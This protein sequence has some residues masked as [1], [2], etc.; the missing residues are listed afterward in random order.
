MKNVPCGTSSVTCSKAATIKIGSGSN[1][2]VINLVKGQNYGMK[3]YKRIQTRD[4]GVLISFEVFDLGLVIHWDKGNR[5]YI[6]LTPKWKGNVAGLCGNFNGD[7][8]DDFKTPSNMIE[9]SPN[10][11]GDSWKLHQ[12]C[13]SV[14]NIEVLNI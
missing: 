4:T 13:P 3:T 14:Q 6:R 11:F 9:A 10:T 5:L 12:Y 2:E 8:Q 1:T 7:S